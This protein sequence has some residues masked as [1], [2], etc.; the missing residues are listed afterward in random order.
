MITTQSTETLGTETPRPE[1]IPRRAKRPHRVTT[2]TGIHI[3][4]SHYARTRDERV[5]DAIIAYYHKL[6]RSLAARFLSGAEPLDDLVQVGTIGLIRAIDRYDPARAL[7]FPAYASPSIV[8]EIKHHFR[9]RTWQ[10]KVPRWLQER[11]LRARRVEQTLLSHLGGAPTAVQIAHE[12]GVTEEEVL[13][14][15]EVGRSTRAV[16]LDVALDPF[17]GEDSP[18]L[19]DQV[20]QRDAALL[21]LE[22]YSDLRRALVCL[23]PREREIIRLRFFDD[24]SQSAVAERLGLSQMHVSRLQQRALDRLRGILC[25]EPR[26]TAS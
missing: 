15:L 26:L 16:S 1:T 4:L 9:D 10:V 13:E 18:T 21:D 24:L 12:L 17:G 6:V 25:D 20:G 2:E 3:L 11:L 7:P 22:A 8:G 14:A 5:R 19:M 23:N